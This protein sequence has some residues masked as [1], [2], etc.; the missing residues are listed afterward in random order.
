MIYLL[1]TTLVIVALGYIIFFVRRDAIVRERL[2][3]AEG[4]IEVAHVRKKISELNRKL[5]DSKL[6]DKLRKSR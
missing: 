1:F 5:T 2:D 4:I 6:R 3:H